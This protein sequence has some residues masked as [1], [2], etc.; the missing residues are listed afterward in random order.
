MFEKK[1]TLSSLRNQIWE[2]V[3]VEIE[4]NNELLLRVSTN[5]ITKLKEHI[6]AGAKLVSKK[7]GI[8]LKNTSR[9]SKPGWKIG[10]ETQIRNLRQ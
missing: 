2:I 8:P 7:I 9:N 10:L 4:K 6:Y 3:K 1:T 5:N